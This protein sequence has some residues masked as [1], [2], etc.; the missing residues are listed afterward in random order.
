MSDAASM[1]LLAGRIVFSGLFLA[2]A[3]GSFTHGKMMIANARSKKMPLAGLAG[4]PAGLYQLLVSISIAAGI[5]PDIGA[6][7]IGIFV[8]PT[9]FYFHNYWTVKDPMQKQQQVFGFYRNV[10]LLGAAIILFAV[11]ASAGDN[12]RFAVTGPL[13]RF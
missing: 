1:V 4:W 8:V 13:F 10:S 12:L 11:F 9:A 6:I 7:L 3:V 2:A 5:W